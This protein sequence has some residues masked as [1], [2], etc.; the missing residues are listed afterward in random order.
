LKLA[1]RDHEYKEL[2]DAYQRLEEQLNDHKQA[3]DSK[4]AEE[5][6]KHDYEAEIRSLKEKISELQIEI[7]IGDEV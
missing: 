7:N 5:E 4:P 2:Q 3:T 1:R 6:P